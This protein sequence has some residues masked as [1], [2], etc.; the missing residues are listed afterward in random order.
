MG[1]RSLGL[2][3]TDQ[4]DRCRSYEPLLRSDEFFS[5]ATAAALYGLPLP[6]ALPAEPEAQ[7]EPEPDPDA[8]PTPLIEVIAPPGVARA[9]SKGVKG[10]VS[11]VAV[12]TGVQHGLPVVSPAFVWCQ[13]A[14]RLDLRDIVAVGDAI[15]TGP[16]KR[17]RRAPALATMVDLEQAVALWGGRRGAVMLGIALPRV[18]VGAESRPETHLRLVIVDAGMP[19]P[20]PNHPTKV[21]SE[22]LHPDLSYPQ[23]RIAIEYLG[24]RHRTD[25]RVWQDDVRRKRAFERAGWRVVEVTSDDLYVDSGG[26]L[27]RLRELIATA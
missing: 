13:M 9:R 15:V 27:A 4:I 8:P 2:D 19:E 25:R 5:H 20:L 11:S 18:R 21:G 7:A 3:L 6:L 22:M 24:D 14:S 10:H 12:P 26:L 16:R 23:W 17:T 1:V